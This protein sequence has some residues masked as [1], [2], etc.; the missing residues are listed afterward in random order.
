MFFIYFY[1]LFLELDLLL[2]KNV[3]YLY[4][5]AKLMMVGASSREAKIRAMCMFPGFLIVA[6][7]DQ[8]T[9]YEI[10]KDLIDLD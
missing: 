8:L 5:I 7:E 4:D 3:F 9:L 6:S 10:D 2:D 1:F